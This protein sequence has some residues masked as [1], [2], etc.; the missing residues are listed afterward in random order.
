[1]NS[2]YQQ[3]FISFCLCILSGFSSCSGELEKKQDVIA[4]RTLLV[5][6]A[7]D[8][9]LSD[10]VWQKIDALVGGWHNASDNL[11]I[12]QDSRGERATPSLMKVIGDGVDPYTQVVKEYPE[13][14]S[15]DPA[16]F[17]GVLRDALNAFPSA[18]YGL[19]L[20]SHGTGW[21][22]KGS[23]RSIMDD[24]GREM[25]IVDFAAAIPDGQFDFIALEACLMASAEVAFELRNK[26]DYL[27]ASSAEILSPGFTPVYAEMLPALFSQ[28]KAVLSEAAGSY[29]CYCNNL[30]IPYRSATISVVR[31]DKMNAL[32][33]AMRKV[34]ALLPEELPSAALHQLQHFDRSDTPRF[35]DAGNLIAYVATISGTES[36]A[37]AEE[38]AKALQEAVV[39]KAATPFFINLPVHSH[40]GL[41]IYIGQAAYPTLNTAWQQTGWGRV[42]NQRISNQAK[43]SNQYE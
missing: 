37:V 8:N 14:N 4:Q 19:L 42:V 23:F 3:C 41:T 36:R 2:F 24:V 21:L 10:E 7:G 26:A 40:S 32:A 30:E 1:M 11:L 18:S 15:A 17:S 27:L 12:Y 29:F 22:P 43:L 5:Y 9:N 16:F 25:E 33:E 13:A 6:L 35:F 20:F 39:Y 38:A 34:Y 28:P 31:L